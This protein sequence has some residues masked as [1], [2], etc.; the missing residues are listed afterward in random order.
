MRGEI[1]HVYLSVKSRFCG[2]GSVT[3]FHGW[4]GST[5]LPSGSL[6]DERLLVA[7]PLVEV[8]AAQQDPDHQVDL[9]QVGRDQLAV[10]GDARRDEPPVAPTPSMV[11]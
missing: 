11:L 2:L 6:L 9:D 10:D 5:S 7:G 4:L 8:G 1:T 3:L